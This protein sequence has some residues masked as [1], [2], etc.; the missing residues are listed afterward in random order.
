MAGDDEKGRAGGEGIPGR[1]GSAKVGVRRA[2]SWGEVPP[3]R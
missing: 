3:R 1:P 2:S